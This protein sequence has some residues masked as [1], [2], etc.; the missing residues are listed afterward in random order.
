MNSILWGASFTEW[1]EYVATSKAAD[2]AAIQLVKD[3]A[4]S[5]ARVGYVVMPQPGADNQPGYAWSKRPDCSK[6][7]VL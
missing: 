3:Q 1:L 4:V 6:D 5:V 2:N 7:L